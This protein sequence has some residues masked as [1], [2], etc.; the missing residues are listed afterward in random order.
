MGKKNERTYRAPRKKKKR[1]RFGD[2]L[3]IVLMVVAFGVFVFAAYTLYG[4]YRNYQEVDR[5]YDNLADLADNGADSQAVDGQ[6]VRDVFW[7]GTMLTL[8]VM[9]NPIDFASL[10]AI[11][12]DLVAWLK[13]PALELS[14]P[15]VQG[16]D[17]EYYLHN[18]F[19]KE[20]LF[21]GC[22]FMNY[23][24][25]PDF[26]DKNT[27]IY[28]HN[29]RNGSM[30]GKLKKFRDESVY[31]TDRSFWVY[32]KDIIFEYEI[33]SARVVGSVGAAY[34]TVFKEEEFQEFLDAAMENSEVDNSM[35]TVSTD[36]HIT[37]LSTC[38]GDSST[39]FVV[40]GRIAQM[41][42]SKE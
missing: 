37:T 7:D 16:E 41:Y 22:L 30:F 40:Q 3:S 6:E 24:N 28:G 35:V 23:D 26:S 1:S 38:T 36:D 9:E 20:D 10:E 18:S 12:S 33:I 21:A 32:T 34:Q 8:P 4:Y 11:N 29:M 42:A 39:R 5:T 19:E 27:I 31:N 25:A 14:Y 17:N 13:V 2:V 15:V